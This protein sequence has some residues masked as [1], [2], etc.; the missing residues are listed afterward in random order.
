MRDVG[1]AITASGMSSETMVAGLCAEFR[2]LDL[3]YGSAA[4]ASVPSRLRCAA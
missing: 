2:A 3:P 1:C 4:Y